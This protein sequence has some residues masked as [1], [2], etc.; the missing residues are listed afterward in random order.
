MEIS[1]PASSQASMPQ[2]LDTAAT[3]SSAAVRN[4]SST[5][6]QQSAAPLESDV[7]SLG[8][9]QM[10]SGDDART[11]RVQALQSQIASG[12]YQVAAQDVASKLFSA[13]AEQG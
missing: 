10:L 11:D 1:S 3:Q 4:D 9:S 8:F 6:G 12:S 13:M 2:P 5:S 7:A